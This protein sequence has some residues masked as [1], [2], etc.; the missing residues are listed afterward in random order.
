MRGGRNAPHDYRALT[1]PSLSGG[2]F[3]YSYVRRFPAELRSD[4]RRSGGNEQR[5]AEQMATALSPTEQQNLIRVVEG[6]YRLRHSPRR[7]PP[8]LLTGLARRPTAPN[9][10]CSAM[11]PP[12]F[13]QGRYYRRRRRH[14]VCQYGNLCMISAD[15][16]GLLQDMVVGMSV[17]ESLSPG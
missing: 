12:K 5:I 8:R 4:H 3:T 14:A 9:T 17:F 7:E 1:S 13:R 6:S 15:H 10:P 16:P 11:L 2:T